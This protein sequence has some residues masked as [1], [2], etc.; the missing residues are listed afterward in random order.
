MHSSTPQL[1]WEADVVIVGGAVGGASTAHALATLG[2]SSIVLERT[3]DFPELNRGDIL[4]PLSLSLLERWGV[5]RH[6]TAMGGYDLVASGF[7]HRVR[8]FLG[9]W[10]F[11]GLAMAHPHQTVLRHTNLHRALYAAFAGHGD[12]VTVHRGAQV[13]SPL[14]DDSGEV[15]RGVTGT[16]GGELFQAVGK[17]VVAAD[18]P[19]SRMRRAAG[20]EFEQL[21]TYDF[22]YMMPTC[23]RPDAPELE[24]R[25]MRYVGGDGLTMLIPLDGGTEVRVP[26]Q[27]PIAE[28]S[29]WRSLAPY[30]L[31]QR[32]VERAPV[33]ESVPGEI[34]GGLHT[35]RV[36]LSH[37]ERYVKGNLC[38]VGDAA[39]VVPPTLGQG[40]N[41]AMLDADVLAAVIRR[42]LD[43]PGTSLD[44]YNQLRRPTNEVVLATSHEQTLAQSATGPTVDENVLRDYAWL[45]DPVRRRE[46][47]ERVAGL[48]NKTAEQFGILGASG[49]VHQ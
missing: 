37:A 46:V 1:R 26:L 31:W 10:G 29:Y 6:I 41:M 39:H 35:Y 24:H 8:G 18:G 38:L 45:A 47:A 27:I 30:D 36:H 44:L 5:L 19:S 40:M 14:F 2:V 3:A 4:Q 16:I 48:Y 49:G 34:E 15:M 25:T 23:P 28:E 12:L 42:G 22:E 21:H 33:L 17:V 20:I 7:H 32:M 9:E 13:S 11:E 43:D